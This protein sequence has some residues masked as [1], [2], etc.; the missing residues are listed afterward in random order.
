MDRVLLG[1]SD[2]ITARTLQKWREVVGE[3][4]EDYGA[5]CCQKDGNYD[6]MDPTYRAHK[7][8]ST[9]PLETTSGLVFL[10]AMLGDEGAL[11]RYEGARRPHVYTDGTV[12]RVFKKKSGKGKGQRRYE[13]KYDDDNLDIELP[14]I[15]ETRQGVRKMLIPEE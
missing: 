3:A 15:T 7:D 12:V 4:V 5:A 2:D 13:I 8:S 14:N 9:R 11:S 10:H 6:Q 1:L